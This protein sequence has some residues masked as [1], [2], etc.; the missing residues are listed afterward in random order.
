MPTWFTVV[1]SLGSSAV[2]GMKKMPNEQ[3]LSVC[4]EQTFYFAIM[5]IKANIYHTLISQLSLKIA[6]IP[7]N[8]Q[9]RKL[10]F[11]DITPSM[12]SQL[13]LQACL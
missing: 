1:Y 9:L 5:T 6:I 7:L 8:L 12:D 11:R 3:I 10:S 4:T 2:P 13:V